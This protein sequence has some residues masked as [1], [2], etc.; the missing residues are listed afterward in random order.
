MVTNCRVTKCLIANYGYATVFNVNGGRIIDSLIDGNRLCQN[1]GAIAIQQ[2]DAASLVDRC[3]ITNNYLANEAHQ[4][5]QA[6]V[7]MTGGTVRNSIIADTRL[8]S[9]RYSNKASGVWVGGGVLENCLVVNNTH[10]ITDASYTVYGVRAAGGTVRNCVIAGNRAVSGE[11]ADWGGTASAFINCATPVPDAAMPGAVAFEYGMLRY[12]DGELVPPLGSALIDAGFTAGWEAT[13]LDYAGLPRLSGTAPDIGPCERQAASFAAVF[14]ADRYAVISYDGTTPF[15]FTLTPVVE[16]DPAGATFEWDLDGD[17]TFE[18]SLGTPDSATAQLSAYGTVTLSL[19]A[20]KGGNS[21]LFSRDFTVGP[22]TLYVVQKNDAAT[23]PY[24][25]WETAATNVNEALRYALDGTTILL[26][27]GTHMINAASAKTD[28]TIIVA[29]GRDVTIRGCTGIREDVVLDAG[30]T[31]RLIELYGPTARLCDL[32]VT[33]GKGGSGSAIYNAGGVISNVLVTANY[34]N[35]YGYGIVYNDN[36]SI[37]DTLFLANCA[38]QNHYGIALYQKGT[39]AFSDRLEF[40]DNHD[41]KQTHHARGAAYIAGGTIRNS[42][43]ISNHLDDTGLKITQSCGLWVEN[44]TA[45]NCTVVGNSYESGVTDVNRA[46]Y[47]NTGA[48][49]VNCLIADNFVTDDADVIP[50]CNA[51]TR[52]TYSCTYP[53]NGLG[54]GCIEAT[55][56]VYTFDREGRIRIYVDGPCRDAATLLDWHAGARDLYG[57]QRIY[58]RHPDIGCAE[59]QHGGGSIFLLR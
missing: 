21:T 37:L 45:A 6:A 15:F 50:N 40:R 4:G 19:K 49:V 26:T 56:N 8:G 20:T 28:G 36:G 9:C 25:T 30:N 33:R 12:N 23:P 48:V 1:G 31:G 38:N 47:A 14:E 5:T 18:Q 39:A 34:M 44:A 13:A 46:L 41:D 58:G 52:I 32:T 10:I 27:N 11:A 2:A 42:L 55:G 53:T 3:T 59:L 29:N 24:A 57:N 7:Y 43:V 35:N 54:A 17:G 51:T 16:G 22:A